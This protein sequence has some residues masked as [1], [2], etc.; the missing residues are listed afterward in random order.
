MK[1]SNFLFIAAITTILSSCA[2]EAKKAES[3]DND[4]IYQKY[5]ARFTEGSDVTYVEAEFRVGAKWDRMETEKTGGDA[6]EFSSPDAITYN[7]ENLVKDKS[8]FTGSYYILDKKGTYNPQHSFVWTDGKGKKYTNS[9]TLNPIKPKDLATKI[10]A[11]DSI[12][13]SWEGGPIMENEVVT[14]TVKGKIDPKKNK[15]ETITKTNTEVG[16]TSIT[17][18]RE[19]IKIFDNV[20]VTFELKRHINI[21][22]KETNTEGGTVNISY[23]SNS[24]GTQ[25]FTDRTRMTSTT[26]G[27]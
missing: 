20:Y 27:F 4:K 6:V 14:L 10:F 11:P 16:A 5:T 18:P 24:V 3:I 9:F 15:Y 8:A 12:R 22:A 1:P 7:G 2:G 25:L 23:N 13:I 21:Q 26:F 17:L 19:M